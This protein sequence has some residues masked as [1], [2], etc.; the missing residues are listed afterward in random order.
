[1]NTYIIK[2]RKDCDLNKIKSSLIRFLRKALFKSRYIA[3]Q[4]KF[5]TENNNIINVGENFIVD[6]KKADEIK[7]Y[8]LFLINYI[9]I[10]KG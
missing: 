7:N 5:Y 8:K 3:I 1:M 6:T 2:L 10:S 9:I 4:L